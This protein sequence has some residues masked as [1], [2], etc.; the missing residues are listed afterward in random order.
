MVVPSALYPLRLALRVHKEAL[1]ATSM[2]WKTLVSPIVRLEKL[3]AAV[4]AFDE[5]VKQADKGYRCVCGRGEWW[6]GGQ[7]RLVG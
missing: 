2:F 6:S 1:L 3:A 5:A 7:E 4:A